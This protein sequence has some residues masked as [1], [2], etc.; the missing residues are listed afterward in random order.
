MCSASSSKFSRFRLGSGAVHYQVFECGDILCDKHTRLHRLDAPRT[1]AHQVRR[2]GQRLKSS[3]FQVQSFSFRLWAVHYQVFECGD[4]LCDKH[5]R[6]HRLDAPRTKAHQVRRH[7]QRLK[8]SSFL[9][10]GSVGRLV[11]PHQTIGSGDI[12]G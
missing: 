5:T 10:T 4:I 11:V 12:V 8:S 2:H 7:W 1:K 6:L 3:S 9:Q